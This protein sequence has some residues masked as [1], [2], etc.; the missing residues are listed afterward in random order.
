VERTLGLEL[1]LPER[2]RGLLER[3]KTALP[4][5]SYDD[6]RRFLMQPPGS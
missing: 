3:D 1:D 4:I 2:L 5:T 6:L